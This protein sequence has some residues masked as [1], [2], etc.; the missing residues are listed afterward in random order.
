LIKYLT[1]EKEVKAT[2]KEEILEGRVMAV[3]TEKDHRC[4]KQ[5]VMNVAKDAR[6]LSNQAMTSQYIVVNAI[7]NV[8]ERKVLADLKE[9]V[10]EEIEEE[11]IEV[12]TEEEIG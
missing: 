4:M 10:L 11:E 1:E 8:V 6:F 7:Q 2:S 5:F 9:E 3:A 12:E